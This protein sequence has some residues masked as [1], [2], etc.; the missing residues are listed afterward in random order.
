MGKSARA[1][2]RG[3]SRA[4]VESLRHG[5]QLLRRRDHR[6]LLAVVVVVYA[7]KGRRVSLVERSSWGLVLR[8]E[9][10]ELGFF[11]S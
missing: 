3:R 4:E 5:H 9:G 11:K 1:R 2:E 8:R 7:A 10:D 6:L